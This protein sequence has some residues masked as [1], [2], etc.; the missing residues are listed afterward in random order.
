M[1]YK[2]KSAYE[3]FIAGSS[4]TSGFG[5]CLN[6]GGTAYIHAT[7]AALALQPFAGVA[8]TATTSGDFFAAVKDG[9][10]NSSVANISTDGYYG[11]VGL[12]ATGK[13]VKTA[14]IYGPIGKRNP[15]GSVFMGGITPGV[16]NVQDYGLKGG[17]ADITPTLNRIQNDIVNATST[18]VGPSGSVIFFPALASPLEYTLQTTFHISAPITLQG[19]GTGGVSGSPVRLKPYAFFKF[20]Q[21]TNSPIGKDGSH[22]SIKGLSIIADATG[23]A[24]WQGGHAYSVGDKILP[25]RYYGNY[26]ECIKAG[27]SAAA[28][29]TSTLWQANHAYLVNDRILPTQYNG[30]YYKCTVAGTSGGYNSEP[31][32]GANAIWPLTGS[33]VNGTSTFTE[34][35]VDTEP[36]WVSHNFSD[37]STVWAPNTAYINGSVVRPTVLG[38]RVFLCTTPAV[39]SGTALSSGTEPTWNTTIGA[40]TTDGYI[41]WTAYNS[42]ATTIT[43]GSAVWGS[44]CAP[45]IY[46]MTRAHVSDC[47]ITGTM[48][49]GMH[50]QAQAAVAATGIVPASN[51]NGFSIDNC[52][53]VQCKIGIRAKGDETNAGNITRTIIQGSATINRAEKGLWDDSFLGNHV[54]GCQSGYHGGENYVI[55]GTYSTCTDCYEEGGIRQSLVDGPSAQIKGNTFSPVISGSSNVCLSATD[56]IVNFRTVTPTHFYPDKVVT[57]GAENYIKTSDDV[58]VSKL[59]YNYPVAGWHNMLHADATTRWSHAFSA[60]AASDGVALFWLPRG[61]KIGSNYVFTDATQVKDNQIK[62]AYR[63]KG[64]KVMLPSSADPN[65]YSEKIVTTDGYDANAWIATHSFVL[66]WP[67]AELTGTRSGY[68][69]EVIIPTSNNA[70][71]RAY[72]V[73]ASTTPYTTGTVQPDWSTVQTLNSTIV[74][75]YITWKNVGS[76]CTYYNTNKIDG[77]TRTITTTYPVVQA[78]KYIFISTAAAPYTI[79]LPA[80]P[81]A[82]ETY[83]IKDFSGN[84]SVNTVTVS[85]NGRNIDGAATFPMSTNYES[86]TVIYNASTNTWGII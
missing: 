39:G 71:N 69:S 31:G 61:Y 78:D 82:N 13:L 49:A 30:H 44:R 48:N 17:A 65:K 62:Q 33:I 55:S 3:L 84:L 24:G 54:F 63:I 4:I 29:A 83:I 25:N 68:Q 20:H 56:G 27:T 8:T 59:H 58:Y 77:Y 21:H 70:G 38:N 40:T 42:D 14:W 35:G 74:D 19:I 50:I 32:F 23:L 51:A 76:A 45:G 10:I 11:Y 37:F 85:G 18:S 16:Y 7:T 22:A 67:Y 75:G 47:T 57:E 79:T 12:D 34:D 1:S 81:I 28:P 80:S 60:G 72:Q 64:D 66:A 41:V 5:V 86:I 46:F 53:I 26:Y 73:I 52:Y 36:D 43:D 2:S 6:A 9:Y 15:D